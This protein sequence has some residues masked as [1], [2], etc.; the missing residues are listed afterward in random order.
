MKKICSVWII[1]SLMIS[2]VLWGVYPV[3]A[4]E[5]VSTDANIE[6]DNAGQTIYVYDSET[7]VA[8][9][10]AALSGYEN[11][12]YKKGGTVP[13]VDTEKVRT[14]TVEADGEIYT[15]AMK[16]IIQQIDMSEERHSLGLGGTRQSAVGGK[17]GDDFSWVISTAGGY[18]MQATWPAYGDKN[19]S[20]IRTYTMSI[21]IPE[22][23]STSG[24]EGNDVANGIDNINMIIQTD[25]DNSWK[26]QQKFY[27]NGT[28]GVA[29]EGSS[30]VNGITLGTWH[31]LATTIK[32]IKQ[33]D[34][35]YRATVLS[36]IDGSKVG[37]CTLGSYKGVNN[38]KIELSIPSSA[39]MIALDD[40]MVYS[41]SYINEEIESLNSNV[42]EIQGQTIYVYDSELTKAEFLALLYSGGKNIEYYQDGFLAQD[43]DIV[44]GGYLNVDG[45]KYTVSMKK[46]FLE[47]DFQ[48][49][50]IVLSAADISAVHSMS[51][52]AGLYGKAE[53][54]YSY[55][56]KAVN[57][58]TETSPY[59]QT[60]AGNGKN[61][62]NI[63]YEISGYLVSGSGTMLKLVLPLYKKDGNTDW[64]IQPY[65][66]SEGKAVFGDVTTTITKDQWHTL[67]VTI[68]P[69]EQ[70]AAM[71]LDQIKITEITLDNFDSV[72]ECRIQPTFPAA[73]DTVKES[74]VAIDDLK[75]YYGVCTSKTVTPVSND[76]S[77]E[78]VGNNIY[79]YR[80]N[81]TKEELL[82]KITAEGV[83]LNY[84]NEKGE[85]ASEKDI[86]KNGTVTVG[87]STYTVWMKKDLFDTIDFSDESDIIDFYQ[88]NTAIYER[89]TGFQGKKTDDYS[90]M[91]STVSGEGEKR[92][93][94]VFGS[95]DE[96]K[97]VTYELNFY[98]PSECINSEGELE[99][100]QLNYFNFVVRRSGSDW[101]LQTKI[102]GDGTV[103]IPNDLFNEDGGFEKND[104]LK[105]EIGL[106]SWHF[107]AVTIIPD[108]N[109]NA[110][111]HI[112]MDGT[113]Y[114]QV[115][116]TDYAGVSEIQ[117][118][119]NAPSSV[120]AAIVLDNYSGYY[121]EY[122]PDA[123]TILT[124]PTGEGVI[125]NSLEGYIGI[126]QEYTVA[127]FKNLYSNSILNLYDDSSMSSNTG[128]NNFGVCGEEEYALFSSP[129]GRCLRGYKVVMLGEDVTAD[130]PVIT[131]ENGKA[132]AETILTGTFENGG[133]AILAIALYNKNGA[134]TAF[135]TA[136]GN[137]TVRDKL[138][139]SLNADTS[140]MTVKAFVWDSL[141]SMKP[142]NDTAKK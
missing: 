39:G 89:Q 32:P 70:K 140:D 115:Y 6:V 41:G 83:V 136:E 60:W 95:P 28:A 62:K 131:V 117:L 23:V 97:P 128:V 73:G 126:Q 122:D 17:S 55:V 9:L 127:E 98:V 123:D 1:L 79:V 66:D 19:A 56:I 111:T 120:P 80:R 43:S 100:N 84:Y 59:F 114:G 142:L 8:Q 11:I 86:V 3:F 25:S 29:N 119:F 118:Q 35:T 92:S 77:I 109:G 42:V 40:Y 50:T 18:G 101:R 130:Q 51:R 96:K 24:N 34:E 37:E 68:Y 93:W 33:A 4:L 91:V 88:F 94:P 61:Q 2:I 58:D 141:S 76:D 49:D 63:T 22:T 38:L 87:E 12:V 133:S 53:D 5:I 72:R 13:E 31:T 99:K 54:D 48:D 67:S 137:V 16:K 57:A 14:G 138:S 26:I 139:V 46:V 90:W 44:N 103:S 125:A 30:T 135:E 52:E 75:G 85:I 78:I 69:V 112:Y 121:G 47:E 108:G 65:L 113:Q 36:Y 7:T 105:E 71:F 82:S 64:S 45:K 110:M 124:C 107:V 132:S 20:T 10:K 134:L 74:W 129:S 116:L 15:V 104:D 21:Y 102:M 27:G 106:N 81:M